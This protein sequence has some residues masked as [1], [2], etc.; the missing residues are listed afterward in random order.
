VLVGAVVAGEGL[1]VG[2][3]DEV[4]VGGAGEAVGVALG[5]D[6][7]VLEPVGAAG[8]S[9]VDAPGGAIT[10]IVVGRETGVVVC[11]LVGVPG[12]VPFV[13]AAGPVTAATG[14]P[15]AFDE[16][17]DTRPTAIRRRPPII[18]PRWAGGH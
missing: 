6:V 8:E 7:G 13:P 18:D 11:W 1:V 9:P 16:H 2:R 4:V 15:P 3:R 17:P 14:V 10:L 12:A 5:V